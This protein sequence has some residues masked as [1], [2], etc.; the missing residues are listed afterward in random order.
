MTTRFEG[1]FGLVTT[2]PTVS[3][4]PIAGGEGRLAP[5]MSYAATG[6]PICP[7]ASSGL[8]VSGAALKLVR[9]VLANKGSRLRL[10]VRFD[11]HGDAP[12]PN[13]SLLLP[14]K[15]VQAT[16]MLVKY[17]SLE[18]TLCTTLLKKL[19]ADIALNPP[20]LKLFA[21]DPLS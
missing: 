20:E 13:Q 2:T 21:L 3:Y 18:L 16:P 12:A 6:E 17:D 7:A 8:D 14:E 1:G 9:L 10:A 19:P 11:A 15:F 5:V 4:A